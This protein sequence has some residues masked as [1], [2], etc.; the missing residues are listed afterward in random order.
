MSEPTAKTR[1][2]LGGA[3]AAMGLCAGLF[4]SYACS[5][6][7]GLAH[8]DDRTFIEAMQQ[9]NEAIQ[10]PVF[11]AS[12]AGA[13]ALTVW[14]LVIE[15]RAG[16]P[17]TARWITAALV[18]AGVSLAV[19]GALNIPLNT[20]LKAAGP[21][22]NITDLARIRAHFEGHWVAWNIVRTLATTA[23]FGCLLRGMNARSHRLHSNQAALPACPQAAQR[24]RADSRG[25][26]DNGSIR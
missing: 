11:F 20:A 1:W 13:P 8:T 19:T 9:I 12:F 6:M 26:L 3:T 4:Y 24:F 16:S 17:Q 14:A 25:L 22:G 21:V 10:N 18:L 5:V 7:P 15:R 2:V 23:S